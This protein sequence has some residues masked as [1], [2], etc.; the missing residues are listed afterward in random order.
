MEKIMM[1]VQSIREWWRTVWA[2]QIAIKEEWA[3][4]KKEKWVEDVERR[5]WNSMWDVKVIRGIEKTD[6]RRW[7]YKDSWNDLEKADLKQ[8]A[9]QL[10]NLTIKLRDSNSIEEKKNLLMK[11]E[12]IIEIL[13]EKNARTWRNPQTWKE[14]KIPSVAKENKYKEIVRKKVGKRLDRLPKDKLDNIL[15]KINSKIDYLEKKRKKKDMLIVKFWSLKR[16]DKN[17]MIL[18]WLRE[19]I[20]E[21]LK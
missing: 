12:K 5:A 13:K 20:E 8:L 3:N 1:E 7:M 11:I 9:E 2:W 19:L 10:V 18:K 16:Y 15:K 6:I 17:I 4:V 21:K 14:I